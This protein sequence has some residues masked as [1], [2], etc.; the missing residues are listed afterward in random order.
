ML[1]E[2]KESS[3]K[4]FLDTEDDLINFKAN[5]F[6]ETDEK[7]LKNK[8]NR[9]RISQFDKMKV[10]I[11]LIQL[12]YSENEIKQINAIKKQE[13]NKLKEKIR[14]VDNLTKISNSLSYQKNLI[15]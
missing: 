12:P 5:E 14:N 7:L 8:S 15:V 2:N 11:I 3:H 10:F 13:M 6:F 9:I 4:I 1:L